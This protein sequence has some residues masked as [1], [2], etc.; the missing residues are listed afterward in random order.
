MKD[1]NH[2]HPVNFEASILTMSSF[3]KTCDAIYYSG[4][5]PTILDA[6]RDQ[7]L[8]SAEK[9]DKK[10]YYRLA[11]LGRDVAHLINSI[12]KTRDATHFHDMRHITYIGENIA[13]LRYDV[14][15]KVAYH[16]Q[17][18]TTV[19]TRIH[20]MLMLSIS[21]MHH[22]FQKIPLK[23]DVTWWGSVTH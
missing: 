12:P 1:K 22:E 3:K 9:D 4:H 21:H 20:Q 16:L 23:V 10:W 17:L 11:H 8:C 13:R 18:D 2:Y 6:W 14:M 19:Q 15:L 5:L 7:L